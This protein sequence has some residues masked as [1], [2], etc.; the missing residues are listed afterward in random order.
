[1]SAQPES[2]STDPATLAS[3]TEVLRSPRGQTLLVV[4]LLVLGTLLV[5]E[6]SL[7]SAFVNYDDPLYVTENYH[8]LQGLSWHNVA[9]TLTATIEANWHPL[10][11][12]SHMADVQF[13]GLHATGH[14]LVNVLLHTLNVVLLFLL[15]RYATD[16]ILP[17]A[18]VA[19]LFALC[20]LNVESVAWISER[21]ALLSTT[22]LL[23]ALFAYGWYAHRPGAGR[24]LMVVLFFALGLMAKPM[25]ITLPFLL[26]LADY[27]PL[28]RFAK[29]SSNPHGK[30]GYGVLKLVGEKIPLLALCAGS[31]LI[32]LYAQR[33]GGA[34]DFGVWLP[35]SLRI[36]NAIYSYL[37][38]IMKGLWP[39]H[40]AVFYPH[41][42]NSLGWWKVS[43][44]GL[45]LLA[46]TVVVWHYR[47]KKYL[48]TGW[49]WYLV[50]LVPVIGIVQVG[51]QA[52]A[53]RYAYVPF[54]GLFIIV[55][56]LGAEWAARIRMSASI[57]T[58][59]AL[60]ALAGYTYVTHIQIGYWRNSYTLFSHALEVTTKNGIAEDNFG[61]A[62][63][64][65][66]RPDLAIRHFESAIEW[67]PQLSTAHYDFGTLL[68]RQN[69]LERAVAEYKLAL[70]YTRN[71]V[72]AARAHNNLGVALSQLNQPGLLSRSLEPRSKSIR[73][74]TTV[75]WVEGLSN[76]NQATSKQREL[77][78]SDRRRS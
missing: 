68:Q 51:N 31:A 27:W 64:E 33:I 39:V 5:Y 42:E 1:M 62:L 63:A 58:S 46:M 17:S 13:F 69:H 60:I 28:E 76:T 56:W 21:K 78:F 24:Y 77:I 18:M 3:L 16:K 45:S 73:M 70:A 6:P 43:A 53:D 38:Y 59:I 37:A 72:E 15:L 23:L 71:P 36:K 74:N 8:V 50:T 26:L 75:F 30:A 7:H 9:W 49:F 61:V 48:L 65:M 40:L 54:V 47:E 57:V 19:A 11:W 29:F 20:P 44:A 10:T 41:P 55:A 22:F 67:M 14:H 66:G 2:S 4:L 34:R 35:L 52:M 32:T 25:V 12:I